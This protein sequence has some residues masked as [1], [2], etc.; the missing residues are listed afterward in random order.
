VNTNPSFP[1]TYN[2]G[3]YEVFWQTP[4]PDIWIS[5]D[6]WFESNFVMNGGHHK[7]LALWEDNYGSGENTDGALQKCYAVQEMNYETVNQ[8]AASIQAV[9][10]DVFRASRFPW[11]LNPVTQKSCATS[12]PAGWSVPSSYC[13]GSTDPY[14]KILDG[15]GDLG[16]WVNLVYHAV[17]KFNVGDQT[18]LFE[19]WKDG[20]LIMST[21]HN[22]YCPGST[23]FGYRRMY[24][25]GNANQGF[26]NQTN[27]Y[28]TNV[29]ISGENI[30]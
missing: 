12:L 27:K 5:F 6:V 2:S 1:G 16:R 9:Q 18:G 21:D 26:L 28:I 30:V 25:M 13:P 11:R 29:T 23:E 19:L 10:Q 3:K 8:S 15:A 7:M 14:A 4:L 22:H 17:P 20:T 24:L